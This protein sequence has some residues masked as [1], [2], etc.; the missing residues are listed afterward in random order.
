MH[1]VCSECS[2]CATGVSE[3]KLRLL[4]DYVS[5]GRVLDVGCGN[6][7]YGLHLETMGCEVLQMDVVDR[8]DPG[9][10]HIP[11]RIADAQRLEVDDPGVFD[12]VIAF[13]IMEHLED[14][15]AFLRQVRRRC[16]RRLILSVPNA[17]DAGLLR[18]GVTHK[19][20]RDRTHRRQYGERQLRDLLAAQGFR[21]VVLCPHYNRNLPHFARLLARE[22]RVSKA[23]AAFIGWQCKALLACG[24]FEYRT[25][26]D[27]YCVAQIDEEPVDGR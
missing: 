19:H 2:L 8:R 13:D 5:P 11:F 21:V 3:G 14:D 16:R 17:E 15:A 27:W 7:L 9:A 25:V 23:A 22:R 12:D 26:G 18:L 6:G 10:R 1:D 4:T 24:I 20:F